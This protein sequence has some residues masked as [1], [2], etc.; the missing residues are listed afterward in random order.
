MDFSHDGKYLAVAERKECKDF[1]SI[2][3]CETWELVK[4]FGVDTEDLCDLKWCA[5]TEQLAVHM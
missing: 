4:Q 1:V 2:Y 3:Y 5:D